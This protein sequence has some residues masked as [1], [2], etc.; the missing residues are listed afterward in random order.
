MVAPAAEL[1]QREKRELSEDW[2]EA[3]GRFWWARGP[4]GDSSQKR[5]AARAGRADRREAFS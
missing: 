4:R 5:V 3:S 2:A 1:V